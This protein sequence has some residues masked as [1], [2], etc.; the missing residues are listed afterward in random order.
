MHTDDD[1]MVKESIPDDLQEEIQEELNTEKE[2]EIKRELQVIVAH[3]NNCFNDWS[4]RHTTSANFNWS[5]LGGR[6]TFVIDDI[7]KLIYK[8]P[9]SDILKKMGVVEP[10]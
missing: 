9:P 2:E 6:K 5:Y 4:K 10:E 7:S 8:K 1:K 3:F